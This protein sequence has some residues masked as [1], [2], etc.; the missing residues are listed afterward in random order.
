MI[1]KK[2]LGIAGL[3]A[4]MIIAGVI[5]YRDTRVSKIEIT[6]KTPDTTK[7]INGITMTGNGNIEVV[8]IEE[9]KLPPTPI[10]VR[11][12]DFTVALDPQIKKIVLGRLDGEVATLQKD[13][14]NVEAWVG[15]GLQRKT[16]GD[17]IGARD[18]WEYAK[19]LNSNNLVVWNNLGDL[20]HFYLKDYKKSEENWKKTIALKPD[21]IQGYR[22]LYELYTYSMKEKINE[23]PVILKEGIAKNPNAT[24]LKA[25]LADY[26]KSVVK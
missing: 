8:P 14:K 12:T 9:K 18:A 3:V 1:N 15:L 23:A 7:S 25:L 26:E 22:G 20:Y 19:A 17:Y 21:Y 11:G 6:E 16:L 5:V 10:L 4:L 24:D 13:T 2:N